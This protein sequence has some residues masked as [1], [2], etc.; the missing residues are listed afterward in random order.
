[1]FNKKSVGNT[2]NACYMPVAVAVLVLLIAFCRMPDR[3]IYGFLWGEDGAAFLVHARSDGLRSLIE[4][5]AGYLNVLPR[6]VTLA[7]VNVAPDYMAPRVLV[8]VSA[9]GLCG[10]SA[11]VY[12]FARRTLSEPFAWA[13]ALTPILV[14]HDGEVWLNITNLQWVI[15]PAFL[16]A[17]WDEFCSDRATESSLPGHIARMLLIVVT[18]LTGPFGMI[19][20]PVIVVAIIAT[21]NRRR[22][23]LAIAAISTYFLCVAIQSAIFVSMPAIPPGTGEP[24][25]PLAQYVHFP[26]KAQFLR[27]LA[28]D[29]V[30]PLSIT[31]RF[32]AHWGIAAIIVT[33]LMFVCF[34]LAERRA[35]IVCFIWAALATF[36]WAISVVRTGTWAFDLKWNLVG[37]RYFYVP[38]VFLTWA[39]LLSAATTRFAIV[40]L[41]ACFL[42]TLSLINSAEF[43]HST[44]WPRVQEIKNPSG[45]G[46]LLTV[47]PHPGWYIS[48]APEP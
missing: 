26:W 45:N 1:M 39:L 38:F 41:V 43:L 16:I 11:Y 22:S 17:L 15:A 44:V 8:W 20:A 12:A 25:I 24:R 18:T 47:P 14:A 28:L 5:Y 9:L 2:G 31:P 7:F 6:L 19:F 27:Y 13:F 40:R 37:A 34:A 35:R 42:L 10:V 30:M 3:L 4:P 29:F 33:A 32:G 23:S 36:V 21:R 48:V 46:W